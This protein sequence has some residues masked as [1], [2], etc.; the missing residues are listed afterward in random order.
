[1]LIIPAVDIRGGRCVRL[2]RGEKE[3]ETV[4]ADDP[5]AVAREFAAAGARRLHVVDL[6]GA[7]AGQM[8]NADL[9]AGIVQAVKIPVQVGGGIRTRQTAE[10]LLDSGVSRVILGTVAVTDPQL[11]A[12]LCARYPGR[13]MA[14]I[15]ARDG[16]VAIRGWVEEAD[17]TAVELARR[18][19]DLGIREIVYT[20]ILRDGTLTGPNLKAL[21]EMAT[22][23]PVEVIASGG[24]SSLEDIRQLL[25]LKK[26]GVK[27]VIIGQALYTGKIS[28]PEALALTEEV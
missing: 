13:I 20:D 14:G 3:R 25:P 22:S 27:G 6:D 4:Y 26:L 15:D 18:L 11:V 10:K 21:R 1:M 17:L 9:I 8:Q 12:D 2:V 7:F 5:V 28:L 23:A 16:M 24:M 19:A